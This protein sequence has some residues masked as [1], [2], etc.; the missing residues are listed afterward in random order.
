MRHIAVVR[1]SALGDVLLATPALEAL[2]EREPEAVLT[3]VTR[4]AYAPLLDG[5][6][7]LDRVVP[8]DQRRHRGR[9]GLLRLARDITAPGPVDLFVDLQNKVRTHLLARATGA[10]KRLVYR[11]RTVL[12]G[13][14]SLLGYDPPLRGVHASR[15]YLAAL[16]PLG[17]ERGGDAPLRPRV[18]VPSSAR[19]RAA[20]W[21]KGAAPIAVAPGARHAT[22]RWPVDRFAV[23]AAELARTGGGPLVAIGGPEDGALLDAFRAAVARQGAAVAADTRD[24]DLATVAA[25]LER[26]RL[27][28]TNDTGPAHLASAVGTP[29]VVVFGPTA[30]ERWAPAGARIVRLPLDCAPCTNH[31]G[32]LCPEGHHRCMADLDPDLVLSAARASLGVSG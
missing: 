21:P 3:F 1:L 5:L 15:G 27:L 8:F 26:A 2:K 28:V 7:F 24:L 10:R 13:L 29:V 6:T 23:V 4:A 18:H 22:K 9:S 16:A 14:G 11:R 25:V 31:G 20:A 19:Q 12:Q 32:A 17:V 30:E